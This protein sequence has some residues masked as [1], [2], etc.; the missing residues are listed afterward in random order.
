[1]ANPNPCGAT[2]PYRPGMEWTCRKTAAHV[3]HPG[4]YARQHMDSKNSP[5]MYWDPT[6]EEIA[7]YQA[8]ITND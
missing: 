1:M 5:S 6:D 3:L 2:K 7:N 4:K 8:R